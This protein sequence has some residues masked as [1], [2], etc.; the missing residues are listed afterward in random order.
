[1]HEKALLE[2]TLFGL[3]MLG[4]NMPSGRGGNVGHRRRSINADCRSRRARRFRS[5]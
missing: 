2:A 1:M 4:V 5:G 3:P